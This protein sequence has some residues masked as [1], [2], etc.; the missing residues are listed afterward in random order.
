MLVGL[1]VKPSLTCLNNSKRQQFP[2]Q[3]QDKEKPP[4]KPKKVDDAFVGDKKISLLGRQGLQWR[5]QV[6]KRQLR[7]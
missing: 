7:K 1:K 2:P 4:K 5:L 3:T 6:G